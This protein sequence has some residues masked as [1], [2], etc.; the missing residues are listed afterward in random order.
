MAKQD[1]DQVEQQTGN[2]PARGSLGVSGS[3]T[4]FQV[5]RAETT[6]LV[7]SGT[8]QRTAQD[9]IVGNTPL[10][11][12]ISALADEAAKIVDKAL[13]EEEAV[14]ERETRLN[15]Q[16]REAVMR[17]HQ[18]KEPR[19][20]RRARKNEYVLRGVVSDR[21][22]GEPI[23]GLLIEAIDQRGERHDVLGVDVTDLK[24]RYELAWGTEE[25]GE[26]GEGEPEVF[27]RVRVGGDARLAV[28]TQPV[29]L[30]VGKATALDVGL[31]EKNAAAAKRLTSR[32]EWLDLSRLET[33]DRTRMVR[34]IQHRHVQALG[35]GLKELIGR[36]ADL[37]SDQPESDA[38]E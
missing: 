26:G 29:A 27:V 4:A 34:E 9:V 6:Q 5:V 17:R 19:R 38:S 35:T 10:D 11:R 15:T 16:L 18:E 25:L 7:E 24:G 12:A 20:L 14:V 22:D 31:P 28:R 33:L 36:A 2:A 37:C 23:P 1:V 8:L 3:E 32:R 30:G 13:S 21:K